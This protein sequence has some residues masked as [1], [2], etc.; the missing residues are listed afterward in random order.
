[1]TRQHSQGHGHEIVEA[2][3]LRDES[4]RAEGRTD[5]VL[6]E[7]RCEKRLRV[8]RAEPDNVTRGK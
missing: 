3:E 8:V 4:G 7:Y 1:M 2:E 5:G 6:C